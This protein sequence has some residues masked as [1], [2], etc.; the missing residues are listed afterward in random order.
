MKKKKKKKPWK[1]KRKKVFFR[2]NTS[3]RAYENKI[4]TL[5]RVTLFFFKIRMIEMKEVKGEE[6]EE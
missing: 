4:I 3:K 2:I 6:R 5:T 1:Q